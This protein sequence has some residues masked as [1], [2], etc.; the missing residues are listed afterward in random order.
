GG[1]FGGAKPDPAL[2]NYKFWDHMKDFK[3]TIKIPAHSL[4]F[5]EAYFIK[6]LAGSISLTRDE[7]KRIVDS[8]PKLRQEQ[9]DELV[10]ILEEE[11]EKFIEL[12]PKHAAQLKKLEEEHKRD[13]QDI[14]SMYVQESKK[15]EEATKVDDIKKQLGI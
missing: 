7:K 6:L 2:A 1:G 9:V 13:W 14:E 12:S 5:D 4:K 8:I 11:R 10:K 15:K 3:T